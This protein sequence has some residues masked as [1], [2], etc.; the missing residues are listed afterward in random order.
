[1]K[2]RFTHASSRRAVFQ[3]IRRSPALAILLI[4]TAGSLSTARADSPIVTLITPN[5]SL[6]KAGNWSGSGDPTGNPP[7]TGTTGQIAEG[8]SANPIGW[9]NN[10][11]VGGTLGDLDFVSGAT[12]LVI[13]D[14]TTKSANTNEP[15]TLGGS[16]LNS[17]ANTVLANSSG[18]TI[19]FEN[20]VAPSGDDSTESG[21][22]IYTLGNPANV[23]QATASSNLIIDDEIQ[24]TGAALTFLGGGSFS[25][26][27]ATLE[28]GAGS[29]N[30]VTG[31]V[32]PNA[33]TPAN[34]GSFT[35]SAVVQSSDKNS[36]TGG[37][38]IGDAGGTANAGVAQIDGA[39][40]LPTTGAVTVNTNSQ[41]LLKG[42]ATYG[43]I[44]QSLTLNG[45]GTTTT[46]GA[47]VTNSGDAS[48]WQGTINVASA[49]SINVQ[50]AAGSLVIS[51]SISGSS[52]LEKIGAG[53]LNLSGDNNAFTGGL[54]VASGS[55]VAANLNSLVS[56][57]VSVTGGTLGTNVP[58]ANI[59]GALSLSTGV[60][61]PNDD[62]FSL[63]TG[64]DFTMTGGTLDFTYGATASGSIASAGGGSSFSINGGTL[65]LGGGSWNTSDTYDLFSGFG[66]G[67]VSNLNITDYS[68]PGYQPE[69]SDSGVLS[70][71]AV[72]EPSTWATILSGLATLMVFQSRR[73]RNRGRANFRPNA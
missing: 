67:S 68:T 45:T 71:A 35:G 30:D 18:K 20:D 11:N 36:F 24:G 55:A 29:A 9:N 26:T 69:L 5:T 41:L 14:Y 8:A 66:S 48:T 3:A 38:T 53:A 49:S 65:D 27:G 23:I 25:A 10:T 28:L 39:N 4:G 17:V 46:S 22:T 34:A 50:G 58:T 37:L 43:G 19:T 70:F 15:I 57:G 33:P 44:G 54:Q 52:Q 13:G 16:T 32:A 73:S 40:A 7:T 56:T 59:G 1:M 61:A 62:S 21:L 51:G 64:R 2:N 12:T 42:G 63:A 47:L 31:G 60:V 72:P 6:L